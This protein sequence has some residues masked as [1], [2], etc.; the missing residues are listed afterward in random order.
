VIDQVPHQRGANPTAITQRRED[1]RRATKT[2]AWFSF[3][4]VGAGRWLMLSMIA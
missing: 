3:E 4:H 1:S 2:A